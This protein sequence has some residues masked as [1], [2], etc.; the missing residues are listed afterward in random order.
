MIA[1][2]GARDQRA[3]LRERDP[4]VQRY[5]AFFAH[6]DWSVVPAREATRGLAE[7]RGNHVRRS[8]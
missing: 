7:Y 5:R 1:V 4:L 8:P 6:L 2:G 3:L